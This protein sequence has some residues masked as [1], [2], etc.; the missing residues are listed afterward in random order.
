M[1][2]IHANLPAVEACLK[3]IAIDS[4]DM[5]VCLGDIVGYGPWSLE[6]MQLIQQWCDRIVRGNHEHYMDI[7]GWFEKDKCPPVFEGDKYAIETAKDWQ[8][9]YLGSLPLIEMI[10]ELDLVFAHSCFVDPLDFDYLDCVE[11]MVMEFIFM[12]GRIGLIGHTH[13]AA[14]SCPGKFQ[15][16]P[17]GTYV[18]DNTCRYIIN[19]GSVGQPRDGNPDACYVLLDFGG[20]EVRFIIRRVPYNISPVIQ[21]MMSLGFDLNNAQRLLYGK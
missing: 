1:S 4:P 19:V 14:I 12:F 18:L 8:K 10:P 15:L 2:D 3:Q 11:K 17:E 7:I 6:V 20:K 13:K 16:V 5:I 21:K 9:D